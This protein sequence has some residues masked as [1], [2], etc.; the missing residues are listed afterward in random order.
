MI[1]LGSN[2]G[3]PGLTVLGIPGL[4]LEQ[5]VQIQLYVLLGDIQ[6]PDPMDW[7][8]VRG[9]SNLQF[10]VLL[11]WVGCPLFPKGH[12]ERADDSSL[13]IGQMIHW[14]DRIGDS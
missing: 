2:G 11:E 1:G 3:D 7:R 6:I 14:R 8:S 9:C 10:L 4:V 5:L 12:L 13:P